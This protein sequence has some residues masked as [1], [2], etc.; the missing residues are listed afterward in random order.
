MAATKKKPPSSASSRSEEKSDGQPDELEA[1]RAE[2][3]WYREREAQLLLYAA[4]KSDQLDILT[5]D[6]KERGLTFEDGTVQVVYAEHGEKI[7][8]RGPWSSGDK[9][10]L[11]DDDWDPPSA[12]AAVVIACEEKTL[13]EAL[14][15]VAIMDCERAI[16]QAFRNARDG[17][18]D[19]NG[20]L[21]DTCFL[22]LFKQVLKV[23]ETLRR[24]PKRGDSVRVVGRSEHHGKTGSVWFSEDRREQG[25]RLMVTISVANPRSIGGSQPVSL[26][27]EDIE[28]LPSEEERARDA[29]VSEERRT[30]ARISQENVHLHENLTT[31]QERCGHLLLAARTMRD[32]ILELGGDDPGS[33]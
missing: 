2:L 33:P 21:W 13:A 11:A 14:S 1:L 18:S 7:P 27:I 12:G 20:A 8:R 28:V 5:L 15:A 3:A 9:E 23:F 25:G 26:P 17:R 10:R 16:R 29:K 32:R 19:P 4:G 6:P 30:L 24:E 22:S 31:T